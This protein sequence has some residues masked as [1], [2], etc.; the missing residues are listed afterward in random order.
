MRCLSLAL[1]FAGTMSLAWSQTPAPKSAPA[2]PEQLR[3]AVED[4]AHSRFAV[5]EKA[6][7][8]L[9]EAGRLAEPVLREAA[10]SKDEETTNRA[11]SILEKFDWGIYPDT[12]PDLLKLIE[13]FRGGDQ[14][15]RQ[16]VLADMMRLKPTRF[17]TLRKLIARE[18]NPD[19]RK[20]MYFN[21][22]FQ[23]RATV[24]VLIVAN[25]L[26]EAGEL[27]EICLSHGNNASLGDFATFLYLRKQ[28]DL[29][30]K[31]LEAEVALLKGTDRVRAQETLAY[32]YRTKKDWKQAAK[33]A[34]AADNKELRSDVAWESNDWKT[35]AAA[36]LVRGEDDGDQRGLAAAYHRISG[37]KA[38][39][40]EAIAELR[41]DLNGVE[42]D[43][44]T[45]RE[46]AK[47]LLLNGE[48]GEAIKLLKDRPGTASAIVFDLLCAQLKFR[49]AFAFADKALKEIEKE[50]DFEVRQL[51]LN[52]RRVIILSNLGETDSATQLCRKQL[53][54]IQMKP[55]LVPQAS[56]IVKDLVRA[57][58]RN[59]AIECASK[60]SSM[61]LNRRGDREDITD[62]FD[63]LYED[64]GFVPFTWWQVIRKAEGEK[65]PLEQFQRLEKLF[66]GKGAAK[67]IEL[68]EKGLTHKLEPERPSGPFAPPVDRRQNDFAL[69][70]L[71]RR[72]RDSK[73]ADAAY[74]RSVGLK[75]PKPQPKVKTETPSNGVEFEPND[76]S[77]EE[78]FSHEKLLGYADFLSKDG[79]H[80]EAAEMYERA[81]KSQP[82]HPLALF[83]QGQSL[84]KAGEEKKGRPIIE[85]S[86]WVPLG[87][88]VVRSMFGDEL[89]KRGFDEDS[90]REM[91]LILD[92]G[93][94]RSFYVGNVHLR[95]ARLLARQKDFAGAARYYEKDVIS[96]FRTGATFQDPR[97][98]LTVPELSRSYRLRA[99]LAAG[100]VDE[101]LKEARQSLDLLPGNVELAIDFVPEL[102]RSGRKKEADGLYKQ[103]RDAY[104]SAIKDFGS[105][106]D[107]RNS[108]A[109][110]MVNC[111]R[112]LEEAKKHAEKAVA[113]HPNSAGYID[114][115]AEIHFR[116]K[117]RPKALELMKKCAQ[118]EP[119]SPYFRK[120]LER[121]EKK[122]FDSK[123]PDEETGDD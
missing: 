13:N 32:L 22:S 23:A 39:Y 107:L 85:A 58:H 61:L 48:G 6:S 119:K 87:N 76:V 29:T 43:D 112:D 24:P 7:R 77:D 89:A 69:A 40:D 30:I 12:P 17:S 15:Q 111:N 54:I 35:L 55:Q 64:M 72:H 11:K 67:D 114:T 90:R 28:T 45:A 79:R 100:K 56:L 4:L 96:L 50:E 70:E 95:M 26:D 21:L 101:A 68:L 118:L 103:L 82:D 98:Y 18:T 91:Q 104:E 49:E 93:W 88:E 33:Y 41:K 44:F 113:L 31:R 108:L 20:E 65:D 86:H 63:R 78:A 57:G 71:Y 121:F 97:A 27:L 34:S 109:W 38:K 116:L 94:F 25:Q 106:G 51:E 19:L 9:W 80:K 60:V 117:D 59:L 122:A 99:M 110:V 123:P 120:Q 14:N 115:L 105:S 1:L 42:G 3:K 81:W 47:A 5:R 84:V 62:V 37:D 73:K 46:F 102:D 8:T 52:F 2:T 92:T 36:P 66:A 83:L 16:Q 10:Q 75:T 74:R 53:D